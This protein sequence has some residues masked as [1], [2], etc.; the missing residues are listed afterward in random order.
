MTT[1]AST[2]APRAKAPS[3]SVL[4][5]RWIRDRILSQEF[6]PGS[7]LVLSSIAT[8]LGMSVVPVR[9]ALRQLEAEGLVTF[10]HNVGAHVS[11]V[12]DSAYLESM[13]TLAVLEGAATAMAARG[14]TEDDLPD[15]MA[16]THAVISRRVDDYWRARGK[17]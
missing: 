8:D 15:L 6:T 12:D 4:A 10:E 5:Y 3:K 11:M 7:R 9:E 1:T 14:L 17:L 2:S 13:Q 16:R